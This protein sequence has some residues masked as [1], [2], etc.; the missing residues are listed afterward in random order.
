VTRIA[1]GLVVLAALGTVVA[2]IW[3]GSLVAERPVVASPYEE[4]LGYEAER[5][6]REALGWKVRLATTPLSPGDAMLEFDLLDRTDAPVPD[7]TVTL[8]VGRP[9]TGR[10]DHSYLARLRGVGQYQAAVRFPGPGPWRIRFD[11]R[12]GGDRV[13]VE[14]TVAVAEAVPCELAS[15]ACAR[16]IGGGAAL[17]LELSPRPLRAMRDLQVEASLARDGKAIEGAEVAV[18]FAMPGMEMGPNRVALKPAG[19]GRYRGQGVLVRCPSGRRDW[20]AEVEVRLPGV[21]EPW[22]GAFPFAVAE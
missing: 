21:A 9:D 14:R 22:R 7:A 11:A 17:T 13:R 6:G 18:S 3:V 19:S 8:R 16:P 2:T 20:V 5:Q 1:L 4:G 10:D 12:R 15:G